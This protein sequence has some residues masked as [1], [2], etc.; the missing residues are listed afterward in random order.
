MFDPYRKWLG[1]PEDRRPPTHYQLLGI[2]PDERDLDVIEAAVLRQSSF[3]RNFQT[4]PHADDATRILNEI[5]AARLCL[6][7]PRKRAKY[8]AQLRGPSAP[9]PPSHSSARHSDLSIDVPA[10]PATAPPRAASAPPPPRPALDLDR[11]LPPT[12]R[13]AAARD[14]R[15]SGGRAL[16]RRRAASASAGYI[17]QVPLV[18]VV[19]IVLSFIAR[20]LGQTIA[21]QHA[22]RQPAVPVE[23]PRVE[24]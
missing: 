16:G 8:D 9:P 5:A 15:L 7:D 6:V 14:T 23:A 2:Q 19:L 18:A 3:V 13:R 21:E 22:P 10:A 4:G 24:E 20:T 11:L 17:W 12:P 1:I